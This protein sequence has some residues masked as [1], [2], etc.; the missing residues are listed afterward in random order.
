M[1]DAVNAVQP[2]YRAHTYRPPGAAPERGSVDATVAAAVAAHDV[3]LALYPKHKD[4]LVVALDATLH[5]AGLGRAVE[6]GR[7]LGAAAAAAMLAARANDGSRAGDGDG[8]YTPGTRPG[9]WQFTPGFDFIAAPHWR[10]VKPFTM[11]APEQFRV[12]APPP[13]GSA[14]YAAAFDEVKATGSQ[15][16]GARRSA[17]QTQYAAYWYEFSDIGWNRIARVVARDKTVLAARARLEIGRLALEAG[18]A[19]E[20]LAEFLKV[21]LLFADSE[22][23]SEALYLA[24]SA[25]ERMGDRDKAEAQYREL[26]EKHPKTEAAA[27][28]QQRLGELGR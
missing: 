5:D 22:E 7:K 26:I 8:A 12:A 21:A 15:A 11:R 16:A 1:H 4:L 9:D 24:G 23:V 10:A 17:E 20:A 13:L 27:R 2:R 3:L 19:E 25:L 6:Q 18:S 28:A 14:A